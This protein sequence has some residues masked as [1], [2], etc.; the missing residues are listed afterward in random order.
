M[1]VLQS[2]CTLPLS[3]TLAAHCSSR[4]LLTIII[5][6]KKVEIQELS[7][8][9]TADWVRRVACSHS[10]CLLHVHP[11]HAAT[12]SACCMYTQWEKPVNFPLK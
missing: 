10:L 12:L 9:L 4:L 11:L 1:R 2:F 8:G 7:H 5:N 6:R 3:S